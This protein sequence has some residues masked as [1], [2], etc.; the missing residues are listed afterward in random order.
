LVLLIIVGRHKK[1]STAGETAESVVQ[2]C[3]G[4]QENRVSAYAA[5]ANSINRELAHCE[6]RYAATEKL[7]SSVHY[8]SFFYKMPGEREWGKEVPLSP[9]FSNK[10]AQ[11]PPWASRGQNPLYP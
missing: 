9:F 6:K 5:C 1:I 10:T 4:M 11:K 2:G 3:G 8:G 7:V